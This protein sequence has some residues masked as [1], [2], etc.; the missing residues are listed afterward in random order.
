MQGLS[1]NQTVE[2]LESDAYP[3]VETIMRFLRPETSM[4]TEEHS[5]A[6]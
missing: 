5:R 1:L 6:D 3:Q 2:F 4:S